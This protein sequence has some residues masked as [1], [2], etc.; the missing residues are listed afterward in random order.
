MKKKSDGYWLFFGSF[1]ACVGGACFGP[2]GL[3]A[4]GLVGAVIGLLKEEGKN[5]IQ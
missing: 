2:I 4:G 5:Q 1:G 3:I